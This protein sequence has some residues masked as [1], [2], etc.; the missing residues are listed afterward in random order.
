MLRDKWKSFAI[1]CISALCFLEMYVALFPTISKQ[2]G[3]LDSLLKNLPPEMFKAMG[4]DH[5]ALSFGNMESFLSTEY[6]SF[7]WPI[8]AII[9]AITIANYISVNEIDKGT[10]ET[11]SSLP[12]NRFRIFIERYAAGLLLLF[13]FCIVSIFGVV[14]LAMIHGLDYVFVNYLTTAIGSF[15]F[16]WVVYSLATLFSVIF[17][18]KGRATMFSGGILIF[19]YV[20]QIVTSLNENVK[21]L[22]YISFFNYFN[23]SDLLSKNIYPEYSLLVLGG[24][25]LIISILALL[26]F[27]R[28][29]LSV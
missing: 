15:F 21:N 8:L 24:S 22:K 13:G 27:Q 6:M 7:L 29:D 23:G 9:F 5:S 28:R 20:I 25:A 1:Y 4:I 2:S 19:M 11:L 16:I 10:I 3:Q 18:E 26:W 14:P 12:A 17:S